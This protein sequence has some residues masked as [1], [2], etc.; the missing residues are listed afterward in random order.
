MN[1]LEIKVGEKFEGK[2]SGVK[3]EIV[4]FERDE[5]IIRELETGRQFHYCV[6]ALRRCEMVKSKEEGK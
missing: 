2:R 3:M 4:G 6:D 5:A 1:D